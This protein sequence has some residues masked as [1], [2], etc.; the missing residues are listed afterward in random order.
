MRA[1]ENFQN[2]VYPN[3]I[4]ETAWE[5]LSLP[6]DLWEQLARDSLWKAC[7]E[8]ENGV[9]FW[10]LENSHTDKPVSELTLTLVPTGA[11]E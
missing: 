6:E 4:P 1:R 8:A 9:K 2:P 10:S 3:I 11:Q 7:K 5:P